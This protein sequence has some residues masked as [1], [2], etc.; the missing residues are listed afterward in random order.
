MI[1]NF[2]MDKSKSK[3]KPPPPKKKKNNNDSGSVPPRFPV[4]PPPPL[5][6]SRVLVPSSGGTAPP[7]PPPPQPSPPSQEDLDNSFLR[8]S[9]YAPK[10]VTGRFLGVQTATREGDLCA[11]LI[12]ISLLHYDT[13][14][15]AWAN[16]EGDFSF[17]L[18]LLAGIPSVHSVN[19]VI[20]V[21]GGKHATTSK[22]KRKKQKTKDGLPIEEAEMGD[23][24]PAADSPA[25]ADT[26]KDAQGRVRIRFAKVT[27]DAFGQPVR[28]SMRGFPHMH[29][30][31]FWFKGQALRLDL[32]YIKLRIATYYTLPSGVP[33]SRKPDV[34]VQRRKINHADNEASNITRMLQYI[35]KSVN[36][37]AKRELWKRY[38]NADAE[39]PLPRLEINERNWRYDTDDQRAT[40]SKR[41]ALNFYLL[42]SDYCTTSL[43]LSDIP[44]NDK[45]LHS[46]TEDT[47]PNQKIRDMR[48]FAGLLTAARVYVGVGSEELRGKF[49][50]LE[51]R[52]EYPV[53]ATF[54]APMELNDLHEM[55][56][57]RVG[58]RA[59]YFFSMYKKDIPDWCLNATQFKLVVGPMNYHWVEL[60]DAYYNIRTNEFHYKYVVD[61]RGIPSLND[62]DDFVP[63]PQPFLN[64]CYRSYLYNSKQ[65]Q[66][67][68]HDGLTR[69]LETIRLIATG[70]LP[71]LKDPSSGSW[72]VSHTPLSPKQLLLLQQ[73]LLRTRREKRETVIYY[74]DSN[75]GKSTL[76]SWVEHLLHEDTIASLDDSKAALAQ[77]HSYTMLI[78]CDEFDKK[79]V[80]RSGLL[81][82]LSNDKSLN[83]RRLHQNGK[84][85]EHPMAPVFIASSER[86]E[87]EKD[88][89][90]SMENR[91]EYVKLTAMILNPSQARQREIEEAHLF[92]CYYLQCVAAKPDA[93][94]NSGARIPP[95]TP[96][97][98]PTP[99][100]TP[101]TPS[102]TSLRAT[103]TPVPAPITPQKQHIPYT[104]APDL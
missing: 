83:K 27:L 44:D 22:P 41:L 52:F 15:V 97:P 98:A 19:G 96:P 10:E 80:T 64:R 81:L 37:P 72:Y 2:L 71:E 34:N 9:D 8:P 60:S 85:I 14:A 33:S 67:G 11:G 38:V 3:R 21:F 79:I 95:P 90:D 65:I 84:R 70:A 25:E 63:N 101:P 50:M 51:E 102:P 92:I 24:E 42:I 53:R 99:I 61:E 74:G 49:F 43:R 7:P 6:K 28:K 69:Y 75:R 46:L 20:E 39:P 59:E 18:A 5:S 89:S 12:T 36:C 30:V 55:L 62:S 86:T 78:T 87:F 91:C 1:L 93:F 48:E 32:D 26:F 100:P 103:P 54:K 31:M 16:A 76:L 104:Y 13:P 82:L 35:Y 47:A 4:K 40:C 94:D 56:T 66:L 88:K 58:S 45:P 68:L 23:D 17:L 57:R 73:R 29:F 77:V